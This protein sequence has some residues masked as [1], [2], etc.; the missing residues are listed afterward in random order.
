MTPSAPAESTA[1]STPERR[2]DSTMTLFGE[3]MSGVSIT[4]AS[5]V[6]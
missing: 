4:F 6:G 3:I 1:A 2:P 5:V